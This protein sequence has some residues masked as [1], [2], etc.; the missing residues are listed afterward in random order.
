M[1]MKEKVLC[2][3]SSMDRIFK[4]TGRRIGLILGRA[5][6]KDSPSGV[7]GDVHHLRKSDSCLVNGGAK[8]TILA[9]MGQYVHV[10]RRA[11]IC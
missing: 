5:E 7:G 8:I 1:T 4:V 11:A 2:E 6:L 9:V 3:P 10:D